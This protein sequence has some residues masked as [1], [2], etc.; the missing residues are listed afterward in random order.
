MTLLILTVL[1]VLAALWG[2]FFV[3]R[4][5]VD[6]EIAEGAPEE[7]ALFARQ[8][9]ALMEGVDEGRFRAAYART[10]TPR[11][12]AYVLGAITAFVLGTPLMLGLL[13]G[14]SYLTARA[15]GEPDFGETAAN[16]K[17]SEGGAA[18][19]AQRLDLE[20]LQI[21]LEAW[22]GFYYF[23]GMLFFWVAIVAVAMWRYH[24]RAPG[25]LMDEVAAPPTT[26]RQ[27]AASPPLSA[28]L[29]SALPSSRAGS[30]DRREA[31]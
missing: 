8:H 21:I 30:A 19:V 4:R 14:I 27:E 13:A 24:A 29:R 15:A 23:F 26:L 11:F 31:R 12:P 20:E 2:G 16:I 17:F 10:Q 5:R 22:S 7:M 9:P 6:A 28:R 3:W 18:R 1:L 25:L